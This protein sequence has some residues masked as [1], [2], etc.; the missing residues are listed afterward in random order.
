MYMY[1]KRM[2]KGKDE[3]ICKKSFIKENGR[4]ETAEN[5]GKMLFFKSWAGTKVRE[6]DTLHVAR[7]SDFD[8]NL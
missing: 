2:T 7:Q 3:W 5:G 4:H 1:L 8:Y 6:S